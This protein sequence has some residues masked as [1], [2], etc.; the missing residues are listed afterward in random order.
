MLNGELKLSQDGNQ[1]RSKNI[2]T[3]ILLDQELMIRPE[4][5]NSLKNATSVVVHWF[6]DCHYVRQTTELKSQQI[7]TESN[8]TH[9]VEA[10]IEASFDQTPPKTL[11]TITSKLITN[12]RSQHKA[13]LPFICQ[14]KSK[15]LA[16]PNKIYGHFETNITIHGKII[17]SMFSQ[18]F[19]IF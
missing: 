3:E 16:D 14:N 9:H 19:L 1:I 6:I 7:F 11:P 12:W 17:D 4:D 5:M 18:I 2:S 15:I 13:D 10:L 8:Q